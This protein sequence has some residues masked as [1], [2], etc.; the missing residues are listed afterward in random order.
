VCDCNTATVCVDTV[1]VDINITRQTNVTMTSSSDRVK[2]RVGESQCA[3]CG[4]TARDDITAKLNVILAIVVASAA[5][6]AYQS[7]T[8]QE[9]ARTSS[10]REGAAGADEVW[11]AG[12]STGNTDDALARS[13]SARRPRLHSVPS[14]LLP[15]PMR[16]WTLPTTALCSLPSLH[17]QAALEG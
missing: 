7:V 17:D 10:D 1:D 14:H 15:G 9:L 6:T 2:G 11:N 3:S 12:K 4:C 8:L 13:V 16:E 5:V